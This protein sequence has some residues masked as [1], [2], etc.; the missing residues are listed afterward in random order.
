MTA[1]ARDQAP[2]RFGWLRPAALLAFRLVVGG[3]LVLHGV[4][5]S[6]HPDRF[7]TQVQSLDVPAPELAATIAILVEIGVGALL[8]AGL[9]TRLA[10]VLLAGHMAVVWAVAHSGS[11]LVVDGRAGIEGE[12]AVLHLVAG[13]ALFAVGAGPFSVDAG[14]GRHSE[15]PPRKHSNGSPSDGAAASNGSHAGSIAMPFRLS[16]SVNGATDHLSSR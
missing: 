2:D 9:F 3:L 13:L 14:L 16:G 8:I 6:Q 4:Q 15:P 1:A 12:T 5:K 7:A 11:A 10:G